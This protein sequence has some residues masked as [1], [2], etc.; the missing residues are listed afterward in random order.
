MRLTDG[1]QQIIL[2]T[3]DGQAV[4][5]QEDDVRPT[6]RSAQG[7]RGVLLKENDEV[8]GMV[9]AEDLADLLTITENGYGKRTPISDYR[10]ISRGG[11]GVINI[12]CTDRN[13]P[14]A[15]IC[16]V[17][18]GDEVMAITKGGVTIRIPV[19]DISIIGRNTQG[20]RIMRLDPS[21]KVVSL[22]RVQGPSA[23]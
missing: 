1:K 4:R 23:P 22:T 7:V 11:S 5:F 13:G 14:V 8:I 9:V 10:L 16:S 3:K 17:K 21:D 19:A 2:A 6:G 20:V 12:Q 15:T 18:D